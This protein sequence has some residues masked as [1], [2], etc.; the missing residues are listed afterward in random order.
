MSLVAGSPTIAAA[1]TTA[2]PQAADA[3]APYPWILGPVLDWLF[4]TGGGVLVLIAFNWAFLGWRVP[5]NTS[6]ASSLFLLTCLFLAQHVFADSHNTATYL[7]LWGSSIDRDRFAFHRTWLVYITLGLF[8][9][10][11][12]WPIVVSYLVFAYLLTVFWHYAAQAFGMALIYCY[13]RGYRLQSFEKQ[14]FKWFILAM[15]GMVII[16][17]L[18]LALYRPTNFFGVEIPSWPVLPEFA[19]HVAMAITA[20]LLVGFIGVILR[21]LALQGQMMPLPALAIVATVGLLGLSSADAAHMLWFY[22][23]GFFHGSQYIAISLAYRLKEEGLGENVSTRQIT[24]VVVGPRGRKYLGLV[25]V[26]GGFFYIVV[27]YFFGQLGFQ[28]AIVAG[29]CLACINFHHFIT[30]AA[31]WKMRDKRCREIL[32]S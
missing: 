15:S 16:R 27:P 18:S 14:I 22:V 2:A 8:A 17:M 29:L 31:I 12:I 5:T 25:I 1:T 30:D 19:F 13:K 20:V 23:P 10:G 24:S 6:D 26:L 3:D 7:R 28:Y 21:K 4:V 32:I 9:A 11:L